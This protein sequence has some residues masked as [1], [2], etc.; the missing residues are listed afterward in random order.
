MHQ[1]ARVAASAPRAP[2]I[3]P[4]RSCRAAEG[5]ANHRARE[6]PAKSQGRFLVLLSFCPVESLQNRPFA[7]MM[8]VIRCHDGYKVIRTTE[9]IRVRTTEVIRVSPPASTLLPAR[10]P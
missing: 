8:R 4:A 7:I 9:V 5:Y 3:V 2:P 1:P 6:S 10:S